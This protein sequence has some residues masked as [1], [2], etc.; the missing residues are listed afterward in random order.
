VIASSSGPRVTR[1]GPSVRA[2][3][4]GD[5]GRALNP[6]DPLGSCF[7]TPAALGPVVTAPRQ[8]LEGTTYLVTRRTAQRQLLLRPSTESNA[9]F[10]YVLAV[11]AERYGVLVHAFCVMSNHYHL[12]VTDRRAELPA[13]AR[14]LD[15][16]VARAMNAS[17][18]RWED[19][20]APP[21]FS[22][23]SL[24]SPDDIIDKIAYTLANPVTAGLVRSGRE[25]PGLRSG[26]ELIGAEPI[27]AN[28]PNTFFRAKGY[29]PQSVELTV[30]PPPGFDHPAELR[31]RVAKELEVREDRAAK[32][33]ATEG[34]GFV[35]T[36]KV[37]AQKPTSRPAPGEP[38]RTLNPRVAARDRWKRLE[39][40]GRLKDFLV[41]Y[42]EAWRRWRAGAR[43]VVFPCGTYLLRVAHGV[44]CAAAA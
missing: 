1:F 11:A 5:I 40:I 29:M 44:S 26:P 7:G 41:R 35:G 43:D 24:A 6:A 33:V 21:S 3:D 15:S 34:R 13:F 23:V 17:L 22:A 25:W 32:T 37:L 2:A 12:V 30:C 8:V 16:L 31:A 20:W 27:V 39:V 28:R 38:R 14:Y 42:R 4:L 10:L 36:A 9:I 19:F 18:G